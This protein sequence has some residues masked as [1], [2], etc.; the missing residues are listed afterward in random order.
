MP[1]SIIFG[2]QY[3]SEGKG[4]ASYLWAKKLSAQVSVRVGGV[5]SGHTVYHKGKKY[6]FQSLP[7]AC[8]HDGVISVLPAGSYL[9][10]EILK[11]E[12]KKTGIARES[13]FI[14]PNAVIIQDIY[15]KKEYDFC[16][17][18][19]IGSTLSGTG[20]AVASRVM[21]G[22]GQAVLLARDV[23]ELKP[24]IHDTKKFLR[25]RLNMGENVVI[26]GTQGYGLSNY[27]AK[28]YPYA[29]SRDT[30][31]AGFL[32]ETGLSPFDVEYVM[33]VIRAFPIRVAGN[34]GPLAREINWEILSSE[35]GSEQKL[36]EFTTV[37]KKVRRI[38][39]F[40]PAIVKESIIAN[41]PNLILLNHVD[42]VDG[43]NKGKDYL[44]DQQIKFVRD[45]ENKIGKKIDYIGND[46]YDWI[47]NN[48]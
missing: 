44:S 28:A 47:S 26:E 11:N 42:Y 17:N 43:R 12:I 37:T 15:T 8:L 35:A 34:S 1:V 3:G 16:M 31:A 29:T 48:R 19:K 45:I 14:D 5:N 2:G 41:Q 46:E 23:P 6:V 38:A 33:M 30:S 40:D 36:E 25:E 32:S 10:L 20:V 18:E 9:N 21:R 22:S 13:L 4:K 7:S 27:H 39:R 24:Y